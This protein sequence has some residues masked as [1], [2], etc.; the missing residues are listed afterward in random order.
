M[1]RTRLS[2]PH[3]WTSRTVRMAKQFANIT[4]LGMSGI[5]SLGDFVRPLMT[6]ASTPYGAGLRPDERQPRHHHEPAR[7]DM[8]LAG[9]GM[10]LMNNVRALRAADTGD[11]FGSRGRL[12]H[13]LGRP[14]TGSS[15][16]TASTSSPNGASVG[17]R[18]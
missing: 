7:K 3:N 12:E 16:P 13:A 4:L 11:V 5:S 17:R 9:T 18:S 15:S 6:G 8:E 14:T 10:D 2:R 1:A